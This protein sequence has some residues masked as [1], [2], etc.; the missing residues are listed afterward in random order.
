MPASPPSSEAAGVAEISFTEEQRLVIHESSSSRQLVEAGPG[1]GKTA[2]ACARIVSLVNKGV[3]PSAILM[4]SFTR[5]AVR[6]MRDRVRGWPSVEST[7]GLK[8]LTVHQTAFNFARGAGSESAD[9]LKGFDVTMS[10]AIGQLTARQGDLLDHLQ[11]LKHL[12]VDEAQDLT[13]ERADFVDA[14]IDALPKEC[15]VTILADSCQSI[16]GFTHDQNDGGREPKMFLD[17]YQP[18]KKKEF[19]R[20]PLTELH[21]TND[22]KLADLFQ[23][24]R[25]ALLT[26]TKDTVLSSIHRELMKTG[27][28]L[29]DRVEEFELKDH[30]LV[31]FRRRAQALQ[32]AQFC[33]CLHRLRLPGYPNALFPWVALCFAGFREGRLNRAKFHELWTANVPEK[34]ADRWTPDR[35]FN[36]LGQFSGDQD[37]IDMRLLRT[38]LAQPRP[39]IDLCFPD[40]GGY[41]PIFSTIHASKGREA[42]RVILMLP[43]KPEVPNGGRP[44][45]EKKIFEEARVLY[46]G[47]T[48]VKKEFAHGVAATLVDSDTLASGSDREVGIPFSRGKNTKFQIGRNGDLSEGLAVSAREPWCGNDELSQKRQDRLV[49]LWRECLDS[50][51]A[52]E[53][54]G[55]RKKV[56]I[57]GQARERYGFY[58][59]EDLIAWSGDGLM[60]DLF[61]AIQLVTA[62]VPGRH[63]P[64]HIIPYLH[65][66]GLRSVAINDDSRLGELCEPYSESG[67]FLAPMI[68]GNA[69]IT[70]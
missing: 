6:E 13:D 28:S 14:L 53:V 24:A 29:G 64:P 16:Y 9:L 10:A 7:G 56:E 49:A 61:A 47:A 40:Y 69:F 18:G 43:R 30:D 17:S 19:L 48:R 23:A 33:P 15:G 55:R 68:V 11:K 35:A 44:T 70:I 41:G 36:V 1:T 66:I 45:S 3:N 60:V 52:A 51:K 4:I 62:K 50:G 54:T 67:F 37:R 65:L 38:V 31:L 57:D 2:V 8:I 22:R 39:P 27:E 32:A 34:L 20:R 42:D 58:A 5:A 12:L 26:E 25:N 63:Y 46:V 59:G 21:R